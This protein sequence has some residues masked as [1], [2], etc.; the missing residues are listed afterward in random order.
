MLLYINRSDAVPVGRRYQY[1][2]KKTF[3][4]FQFF[5]VDIFCSRISNTLSDEAQCL[6]EK[7]E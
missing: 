1:F 6:E 2:G 4:A 5:H 7:Y 3:P